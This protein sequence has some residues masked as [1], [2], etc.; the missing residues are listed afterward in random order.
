MILGRGEATVPVPY[1]ATESADQ[2]GAAQQQPN[3]LGFGVQP[4]G[5]ATQRRLK[6]VLQTSISQRI[7]PEQF[8]PDGKECVSST[9]KQ[10]EPN[11]RV[12]GQR[13]IVPSSVILARQSRIFGSVEQCDSHF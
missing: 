10:P 11:S 6:P 8:F 4:L 7:S 9:G 2:L 3:R 12:L 13:K 1:S 5:C